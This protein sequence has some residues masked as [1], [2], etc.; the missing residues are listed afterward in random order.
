M[1]VKSAVVQYKSIKKDINKNIENILEIS[2]KALQENVKLIVFPEMTTTGY[3]FQGESEILPY[4]EEKT[5]NTFEIISQFA[6]ENNCFIGYG[7]PEK[8]GKYLYNSYNLIDNNGKLLLNYRKVNLYEAD[9]TWATPGNLGYLNVDCELGKIG[10][11]ICMDL[12]FDD[13]IDWH[14]ENKTETLIF[15]LNW[16]EQNINVRKY[17]LFRLGNYKNTV[18]ITNTYEFDSGTLFCGQST[19]FKNGNIE[20]TTANTGEEI[21]YTE[22]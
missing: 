16:L 4:C 20:K 17:W 14:I 5:G 22:I 18:L 11:A 7:F 15:A 6:K 9:T 13:C 19:V 1:G 10:I 3:V 12:N 8:E 21:I 2:K